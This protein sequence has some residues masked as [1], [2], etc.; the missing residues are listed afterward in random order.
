MRRLNDKISV[1][2]QQNNHG[3][4]DGNSKRS[5]Q[6]SA[7]VLQ[8]SNPIIEHFINFLRYPD[9]KHQQIVQ[10]IVLVRNKNGADQ[11]IDAY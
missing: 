5:N 4:F 9:H 6:S 3:S 2:T 11:M 8:E 1:L 7:S 10:D